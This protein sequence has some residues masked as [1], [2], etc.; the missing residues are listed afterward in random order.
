MFQPDLFTAPSPNSAR[1]PVAA[2]AEAPVS[3]ASIIDRLTAICERP[4]YC[5]MVLNLIGQV[6]DDRGVAGP[7]VRVG[8]RRVLIRDWLSD[9]QLPLARRDPR[10]LAIEAEIRADVARENR[11]SMD[12]AALERM[13]HDRLRA[14]MRRSGQTNISRAVSELLRAGLVRRHYAGYRIDH[15][16][17]GAGRTA[18]Y[19]ITRDTLAALRAAPRV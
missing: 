16:N 6:A 5:F 11:A 4:R 3:V 12:K 19:T 1:S 18:I 15:E 7:W 8:E 13:I 17:R 2:A 14:R 9:A 10:R